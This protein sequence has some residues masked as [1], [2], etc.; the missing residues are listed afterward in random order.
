MGEKITT[1][2]YRDENGYTYFF[3]KK[4]ALYADEPVYQ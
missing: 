1:H 4:T 3:N 2:M